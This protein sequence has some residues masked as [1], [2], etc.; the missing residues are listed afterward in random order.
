[1]PIAGG[2][3][4]LRLQAVPGSIG[5]LL[6]QTQLGERD[7]AIVARSLKL[8]AIRLTRRFFDESWIDA[9]VRPN[10]RGGAFCASGIG[11]RIAG[12][13]SSRCSTG[14]IG[15]SPVTPSGVRY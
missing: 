15:A 5:A 2:A 4:P 13:A 14:D 7:E 1:M 10:K 9:P 12:T 8:G 11:W 3:G 6:S